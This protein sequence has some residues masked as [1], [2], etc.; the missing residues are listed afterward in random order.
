MESRRVL[1]AVSAICLAAAAVALAM[2][3]ELVKPAWR[4]RPPAPPVYLWVDRW[5]D[6]MA[7]ALVLLAAM[8]AVAHL[9]RGWESGRPA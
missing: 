9:L 7:Q 8:A 4:P 3:E 5:V 2:A 6:V 1:T